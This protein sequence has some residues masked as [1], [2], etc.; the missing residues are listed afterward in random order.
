MQFS[1]CPD[2]Y[3]KSPPNSQQL[4]K[5]FIFSNLQG[6]FTQIFHL[7]IG[8]GS[9]HRSRTR[10]MELIKDGIGG[11]SLESNNEVLETQKNPRSNQTPGVFYYQLLLV[12]CL[13]LLLRKECCRQDRNCFCVRQIL[14]LSKLCN[15]GSLSGLT[16]VHHCATG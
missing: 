6:T 12:F 3:S 11:G 14:H 13:S 2:H 8:E 10:L 5:F 1:H 4:S 15:H 16:S 9:G 7:M